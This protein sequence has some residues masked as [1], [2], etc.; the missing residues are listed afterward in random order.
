[1]AWVDC[2]FRDNF[3]GCKVHKPNWVARWFF[4]KS[5]PACMYEFQRYAPAKIVCPD[6]EPAPQPIPPHGMKSSGRR[7]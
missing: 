4:P 5:R 7:P 6:R 1:M 2:R 3:G